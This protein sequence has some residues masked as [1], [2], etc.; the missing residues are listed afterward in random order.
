MKPS[1][2]GSYYYLPILQR[3]INKTKAHINRFMSKI[4]AHEISIPIL[5]PVE[6]WKDSG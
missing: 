2:K 1:A 4:D 6:L 5:T 3:S